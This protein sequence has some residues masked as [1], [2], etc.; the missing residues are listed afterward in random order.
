MVV[1]AHL[2]H[3]VRAPALVKG[4]DGIGVAAIILLIALAIILDLIIIG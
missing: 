2:S 4:V 3:V 1:A